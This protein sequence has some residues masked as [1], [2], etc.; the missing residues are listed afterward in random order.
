MRGAVVFE[1]LFCSLRPIFLSFCCARIRL[2]YKLKWQSGNCCLVRETQG[3][4]AV[5]GGTGKG[6]G[7]VSSSKGKKKRK[8]NHFPFSLSFVLFRLSSGKNRWDFS[9]SKKKGM[10]SPAGSSVR[11]RKRGGRGQNTKKSRG[12]KRE[13][14]EPSVSPLSRLFSFSFSAPSFLIPPLTAMTRGSARRTRSS[15]ARQSSL[16][17]GGTTGSA[18]CRAKS[19]AALPRPRTP[20][21]QRRARLSESRARPRARRRRPRL[22]PRLP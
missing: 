12:K 20:Q 9:R 14:K 11:K 18:A 13:I 6:E 4:V 1:G 3:K 2:W 10:K 7:G 5:K 15:R 21:T 16:R 19:P 8:R 17:G 22:C